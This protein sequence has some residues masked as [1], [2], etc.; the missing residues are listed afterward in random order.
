[1]FLKK[2]SI[3]NVFSRMSNSYKNAFYKHLCPRTNI[4]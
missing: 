3:S 4:F 2:K 1:M